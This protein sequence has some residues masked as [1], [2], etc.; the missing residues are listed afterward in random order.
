MEHCT[1]AVST[2]TVEV[3]VG[4]VAWPNV[5]MTTT[6]VTGVGAGAGAV[7]VFAGT[8]SPANRAQGADAFEFACPQTV[9]VRVPSST[10]ICQTYRPPSTV[11]F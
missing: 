10:V 4:C 3:V 9:A 2:F 11:E 7:A 5:G 1:G 6:G 8:G